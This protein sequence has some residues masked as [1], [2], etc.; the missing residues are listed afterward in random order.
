MYAPVFSLARCIIDCGAVQRNFARL[1]KP[2][3]LM[4]V[5]KSDAYGHGLMEVAG[6][7]NAVGA[8][9]FA[10]GLPE[11]GIFLRKMGF[12]Q[13]ILPLMGCNDDKDW[14][15]TFTYGLLALLRNSADLINAVS[16]VSG[17]RL[18]AAI[19][20][21]TGMNR[22]GFDLEDLPFLLEWLRSNPHIVPVYCITHLACADDPDKKEITGEQLDL[23]YRF[24]HALKQKYPQ[25]IIS[26]G[27]SAVALQANKGEI[28][29][30]GLAL[31]GGNPL[32]GTR[33]PESSI[34]LEWAMSLQ[35][36]I[37]A[38]RKLKAGKYVSY[39]AA[40]RAEK[41]MTIAVV[42]IGYSQGYPRS[43]SGRSHAL[44][45]G[46]RVPQ[47]GRICMGM[48]MFD[49]SGLHNVKEGDTVWLAGGEGEDNPVTIQE[50]AAVAGTI[51]YELLCAFGAMN[52][53]EY[54]DR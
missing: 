38:L 18:A 10:V 24:Y 54:A 13:E 14:E 12:K 16:G 53:R 17:T 43:L 29:R 33:L 42:G 48:T 25:I 19:K 5:I 21:N 40:F 27:N 2:E 50:L 35:S 36:K 32:C 30:P 41:D 4:P 31:Y 45:Q 23:F 44:I 51:P 3:N 47:I 26:L 46:R 49:V 6:A 52:P 11:E 34:N 37:I 7:L 1:D 15:A 28:L 8:C 9:R 22:L 39:G 20:V